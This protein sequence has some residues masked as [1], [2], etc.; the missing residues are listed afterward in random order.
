M[1]DPFATVL[2]PVLEPPLEG[3]QANP[4]GAHTSSTSRISVRQSEQV[5]APASLR[6]LS[7]T[8]RPVRT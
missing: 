1:H 5:A 6:P 8:V 7:K 2:D 4:M 3:T